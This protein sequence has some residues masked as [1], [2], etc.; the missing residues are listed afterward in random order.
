MAEV[1]GIDG[2]VDKY[3]ISANLSIGRAYTEIKN[4][5]DGD[6]INLSATTL[7]NVYL[8]FGRLY[9]NDSWTNTR[10]VIHNASEALYTLGGDVQTAVPEVPVTWEELVRNVLG[11]DW[12]VVANEQQYGLPA[13]INA[14]GTHSLDVREKLVL[15]SSGVTGAGSGNHRYVFSPVLVEQNTTITITDVAGDNVIQLMN[16]MEIGSSI[17]SQNTLHLTLRNGST[18]R[19]LNANKFRYLLGGNPLTQVAGEEYTYSEVIQ[20]MFKVVPTST[21]KIGGSYTVDVGDDPVAGALSKAP[22]LSQ[23][24]ERISTRLGSRRGLESLIKTEMQAAIRRLEEGPV[25]FWFLLTDSMRTLTIPDERRLVVPD[26]F[27]REAEMSALWLTQEDGTTYPLVKASEDD[28]YE[29]LTQ[30][31]QPQAYA[32]ANKYF[33]L[34]PMPDLEYK[35]EVMVY[36]RTPAIVEGVDNPWITHAEELVLAATCKTIAMG[37]RDGAAVKMFAAIEAEEY[38]KLVVEHE[39]RSSENLEEVYGGWNG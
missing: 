9:F 25:K 36:R 28:L 3:Y 34:Y 32:L 14:D 10:Y 39:A 37:Q 5:K 20:E 35:I 23:F 11:L 4:F 2:Q 6:T 13:T 30:K 24:I 17:F 33:R 22:S 27:L 18:V 29:E 38:R 7:V 12:P 26:G 1:I 16:G 21:G 8:V 15:V 31:G 19:V